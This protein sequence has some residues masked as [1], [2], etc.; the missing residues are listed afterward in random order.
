MAKTD[1]PPA[2]IVREGWVQRQVQKAEQV[3]QLRE[4]AAKAGPHDP[5]ALTEKQIEEFSKRDD[6]EIF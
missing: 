6:C 3:R 1:D 2:E 5:F 4:N